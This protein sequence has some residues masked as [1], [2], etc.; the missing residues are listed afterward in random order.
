MLLDRVVLTYA[1]NITCNANTTNKR[2]L[3]LIPLNQYISGSNKAIITN[4][5]FVCCT[6]RSL[7][8]G[9]QSVRKRCPSAYL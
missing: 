4:Y 9:K 8:G 6:S 2:G 3:T 5:V 1:K 7:L